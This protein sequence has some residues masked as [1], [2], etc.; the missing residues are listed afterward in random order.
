[1]VKFVSIMSGGETVSP[2]DAQ[3]H[4]EAISTAITIGDIA[5]NFQKQNRLIEN[6]KNLAPI[7][8][9]KSDSFKFTASYIANELASNKIP[10]NGIKYTKLDK[11]GIIVISCMDV[12]TINLI[13]NNDKIFALFHKIDLNFV[14]KNTYIIIIGMSIDIANEFNQDLLDQGIVECLPFKNENRKMVK[15]KCKDEETKNLLLTNHI[16]IGF[17]QRFYTEPY[18]KLPTQCG[19]CKK[20]GHTSNQCNSS[21]VCSSCGSD[22]H[23]SP[24]C[25]AEKK[26]CQNCE[27]NHS[28]FWRGC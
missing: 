5:S 11:V 4:S 6:N 7:I 23:S 3:D 22:E 20:F 16:T 27:G 14:N 9:K 21:E 26:I 13:M 10:K 18:I 2:M 25:N 15:A 12:Q 24:D 28:S 8:V 17:N 19:K 1:M